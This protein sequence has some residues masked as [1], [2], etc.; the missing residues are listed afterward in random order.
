M[1]FITRY[2][3]HTNAQARIL[4][5]SERRAFRALRA[6]NLADLLA[7]CPAARRW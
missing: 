6:A 3:A 7:R 2:C 5:E 4:P 1:T